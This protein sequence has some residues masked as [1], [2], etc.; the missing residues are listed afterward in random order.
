MCAHAYNQDVRICDQMY[1]AITLKGIRTKISSISTGCI[2]G[3]RR[4]D[5]ARRY[6][7]FGYDYFKSIKPVDGENHPSYKRP[8]EV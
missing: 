1:N 7:L 6:E 2:R 3:E 4:W 5:V 8:V